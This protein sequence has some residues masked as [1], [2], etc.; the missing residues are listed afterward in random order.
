LFVFFLFT[1]NDSYFK[2]HEDVSWADHAVF[3]AFLLS[4]AFCL[5][6]SAFYHMASSHSK[7][8]S[9]LFHA[10]YDYVTQNTLTDLPKVAARCNALDYSG[11]IGKLLNTLFDAS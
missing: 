6:C 4:A 2:A 10:R 9:V 11:I 7:Q 1:I 8:V 5:F 3:M